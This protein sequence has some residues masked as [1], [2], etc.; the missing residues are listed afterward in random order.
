MRIERHN[1]V[2]LREIQGFVQLLYV[3][4]G[5]PLCHLKIHDA[6]LCR[7]PL[8]ATNHDIDPCKDKVFQVRDRHASRIFNSW[9]TDLAFMNLSSVYR[10]SA[11]VT[12]DF[13]CSNSLENCSYAFF[14][15]SVR[16]KYQKQSISVYVNPIWLCLQFLEFAQ[17][18]FSDQYSTEI[19]L[20]TKL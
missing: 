20:F 11:P 5:P 13:D 8:P 12:S 10:S 2:Q 17:E 19:I 18:C 6:G 1:F 15:A 14:W 3:V 9:L 16:F 4:L 7:V